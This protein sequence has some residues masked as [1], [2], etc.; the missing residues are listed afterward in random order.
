MSKEKILQEY[1]DI[2]G[3]IYYNE[4]TNTVLLVTFKARGKVK[5]P[6]N[7]KKIR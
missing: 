1:K 7:Y 3:N 4:L 5:I 6:E 2:K